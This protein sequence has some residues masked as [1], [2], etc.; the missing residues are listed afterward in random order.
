MIIDNLTIAGVV[1]ALIAIVM[2]ARC[3]RRCG[4]FRS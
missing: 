1:F 2:I 3:M 4:C